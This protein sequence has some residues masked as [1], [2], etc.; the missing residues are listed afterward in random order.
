V[1]DV[2]KYPFR[3][4]S[5]IEPRLF[6]MRSFHPVYNPELA[7]RVL[8]SVKKSVPAATLVMAGQLKGAEDGVRRLADRL[9]LSEA[10]TFAGFLDD[11]GKRTH[12]QAAD[13]FL[14]TNR[15]DNM[16]VAIVEAAAM[17]LPVVATAVGGVP[18]MLDRGRYGLLVPDDE[19]AMANAVLTLLNDSTIVE[20]LSRE[21]RHLAER[22]G[23]QAVRPLWDE[24]F[25]Q[26]RMR[27]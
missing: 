15:I 27:H 22:S 13:I 19:V 1:I 16:P 8:D 12:G 4:R 21:G 10:V 14:N 18:E 2:S 7:I 9:G 5:R 26:L 3:L 25:E 17:G 6:W 24:L 11:E 20:E 23:W